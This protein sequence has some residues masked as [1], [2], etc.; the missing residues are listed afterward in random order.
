MPQVGFEPTIPESERAKTVRTL[1]RAATVIGKPRNNFTCFNTGTNIF[2]KL[3]MSL[4]HVAPKRPV[5]ADSEQLLERTCSEG[6]S[7]LEL[8]SVL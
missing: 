1:D 7:V 4:M 6:A 3:L 8:R 2:V 5:C